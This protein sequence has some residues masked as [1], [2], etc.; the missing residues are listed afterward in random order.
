MYLKYIYPSF[1]ASEIPLSK[2]FGIIKNDWEVKVPVHY[3]S[4][5]Q[6]DNGMWPNRDEAV[7]TDKV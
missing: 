7:I 2:H 3:V 5:G 6:Q 4:K 1:K